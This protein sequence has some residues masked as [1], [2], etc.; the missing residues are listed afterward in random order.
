M[1]VLTDILSK[2]K[3]PQNKKEFLPYNKSILTRIIA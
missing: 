1:V 3:N 2:M